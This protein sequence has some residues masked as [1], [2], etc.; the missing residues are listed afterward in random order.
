MW[1]TGQGVDSLQCYKRQIINRGFFRFLR[2]E[3]GRNQHT[4]IVQGTCDLETIQE[5]DELRRVVASKQLSFQHEWKIVEAQHAIV[6]VWVHLVQRHNSRHQLAQPLRID[7]VE[8]LKV[9][10]RVII[11]QQN[12]CNDIKTINQ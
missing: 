3:F 1:N 4:F 7:E 10:V 5:A 2:R 12:T 8:I 11:V 6:Y 9:L